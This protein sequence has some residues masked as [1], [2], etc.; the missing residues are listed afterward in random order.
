MRGN[1]S[2]LFHVGQIGKVIEF[3]D[4]PSARV[5]SFRLSALERNALT[6]KLLAKFG[7]TAIT[8]SRGQDSTVSHKVA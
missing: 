5:A 6:K 3:R 1:F 7:S 8:S 4:T 2:S